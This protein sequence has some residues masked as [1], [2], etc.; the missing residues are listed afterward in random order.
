MPEY[1]TGL[2]KK[3]S[4]TSARQL[5]NTCS[6]SYV[7]FLKTAFGQKC[8]L[9]RGAKLIFDEAAFLNLNE[10]SVPKSTLII[11]LTAFY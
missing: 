8:F 11:T 5:R 9:Y 10:P 7:P 2:L 3:L 6:D 1:L 4:E